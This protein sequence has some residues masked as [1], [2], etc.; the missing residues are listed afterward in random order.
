M[1]PEDT[2]KVLAFLQSLTGC[3]WQKDAAAHGYRCEHDMALS[4]DTVRAAMPRLV[5]P[6]ATLAQER[7]EREG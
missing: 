3:E 7:K 4:N 2:A 1:T 5:T 6:T